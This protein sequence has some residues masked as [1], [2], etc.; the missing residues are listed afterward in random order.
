MFP[1][2]ISSYQDELGTV[3]PQVLNE[4]QKIWLVSRSFSYKMLQDEQ[5]SQ[6]L[7]MK[8]VVKISDKINHESTEI[9]NLR[10]YLFSTFKRLVLAEVRKENLH[11]ELE[12]QWIEHLTETFKNKPQTEEEIIYHQILITELEEKMDGWTRKVF[13]Y[14]M[15]GYEYKDLVPDYGSAENVIRSK[16][17]KK[18]K[19]L[20]ILLQNK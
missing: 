5:L 18:I 19:K 12:N 10:A 6:L 14:R 15:L 16:F 8:A 1:E 17:S 13:R 9:N 2:L 7:M 11:H 4:A 20:A 3:S